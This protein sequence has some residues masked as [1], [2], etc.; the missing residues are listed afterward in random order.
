[1][2]IDFNF[3]KF[4]NFFLLKPNTI[5]ELKINILQEFYGYYTDN[6]P[7]DSE[8]MIRVYLN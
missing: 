8:Y 4:H 3:R 6:N 1:M 5:I 7:K 2:I